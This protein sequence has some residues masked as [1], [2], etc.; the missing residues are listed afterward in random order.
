MER[1]YRYRIPHLY[2]YQNLHHPFPPLTHSVP[3][4]HRPSRVWGIRAEIRTRYLKQAKRVNQGTGTYYS[5]NN[6]YV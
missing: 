3:S 1:K 4:R 6:P 2:G 5:R